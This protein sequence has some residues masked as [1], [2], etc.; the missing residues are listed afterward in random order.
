MMKMREYIEAFCEANEYSFYDGYSGRFM[1]GRQCIGIVCD[2]IGECL[3]RLCC[4]LVAEGVDIHPNMLLP[5]SYDNM[6]L[7]L[8]LYFP[9]IA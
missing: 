4:Y 6:G 5:I 9:N 8:I 3:I 7:Q 2:N 1:Y